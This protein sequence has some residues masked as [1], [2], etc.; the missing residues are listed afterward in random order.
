MKWLATTFL[1]L[2]AIAAHAEPKQAQEADPIVLPLVTVCS[3]L[4]PA[5]GFKNKFGEIGFIEGDASV[6]IPDGRTINGKLKFYMNPDFN[7]NTFSVVFEIGDVYCLI[8]S[9]QDA[10]PMLQG[11]RL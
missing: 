11:D 6:Y 9:G 3:P 8:M 7:E 5:E 4:D 1:S 2:L 10:M